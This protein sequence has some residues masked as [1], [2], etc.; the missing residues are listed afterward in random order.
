MDAGVTAASWQARRRNGAAEDVRAHPR[1]RPC[2]DISLSHTRL[3]FRGTF[4]LDVSIVYYTS[5]QQSYAPCAPTTPTP[6]PVKPALGNHL[7]RLRFDHGEMSQ[8][9]LANAVGVTRLTIHSIE[10]GKFSPSALLAFK[11]AR[12][13]GKPVEEV[14]FLKENESP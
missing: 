10:T 3:D 5:C 9:A 11:L 6:R 13:F 8:Q 1:G 4:M 7:R 14:F 12:F 2:R